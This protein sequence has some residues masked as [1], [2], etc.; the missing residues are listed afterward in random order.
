MG[1][2]S[3]QRMKH[4]LFPTVAAMLE[5]VVLSNLLG[6][7]ITAVSPHPL[8][9]QYNKSGSHLLRLE[10]NQGQG[11][12]LILKQISPAT[13]WLMRAT[14][15]TRCRSVTLWE[16]GLLDQLPPEIDHAMLACARD[17]DNWAILLRDVSADLLPTA[18]FSLADH[19]LMLAAMAALHAAFW[20]SPRLADPELGLCEL[21]DVYTMFA[22]QTGE[23]EA[24]GTDEVPQRILEGWE[25]V[26]TAVPPD[27]ADTVLTLLHDP[28][29]LC[30]ALDRY[31]HTLV[32]GDW[33]HANQGISRSH[34]PQLILLDWQ[35]AVAAPPGVELGRGLGTNS[36]L[37][38]VS[39]EAAIAFYRQELA[40]RLGP[41]FEAAWWEPQLALGLL[42]GFVQDGWAI[43]L[44]A[45]HWHVG[46][47]ARAH[48]QA[49]LA[50]WAEQ[51]RA[52]A[53]WL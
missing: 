28:A 15:D 37:L 2:G 4:P 39:K 51:V 5:T 18:R 21:R 50:W 29:P 45:T 33:R 32:H 49:D 10:L 43:V 35:L 27:V 42:G 12:S 3:S 9:A 48:W 14:N 31:P 8:I 13:D 52:G 30:A 44:K 16:H 41:C 17:G 22:P 25:L 34:P 6:D 36:A 20:S 40:R 53:K 19:E 1:S 23:R 46:A 38:P 24:G 11:P 7:Q 26:K 47:A